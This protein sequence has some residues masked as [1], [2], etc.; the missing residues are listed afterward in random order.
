LFREDCEDT[1]GELAEGVV[2][3]TAGA[4]DYTFGHPE[5]RWDNSMKINGCHALRKPGIR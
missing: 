1:L 3:A 4:A 5:T 2:R